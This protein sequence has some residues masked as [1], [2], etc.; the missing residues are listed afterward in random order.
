MLILLL[1]LAV[2]AY[3]AFASYY[4]YTVRCEGYQLQLICETMF[5]IKKMFFSIDSS[6]HERSKIKQHFTPIPQACSNCSLFYAV[7]DCLGKTSNYYYCFSSNRYEFNMFVLFLPSIF[8]SPPLPIWLFLYLSPSSLSTTLS[9]SILSCQLCI[10]RVILLHYC[11]RYTVLHNT[12]VFVGNLH[13]NEIQTIQIKYSNQIELTMHILCVWHNSQVE[14][15]SFSVPI[16]GA[17]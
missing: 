16:G 3:Y 11:F 6:N 5:S 15:A 9:L 7:D 12:C 8:R 17:R 14:C 1:L 10:F 13:L 2:F 4:C